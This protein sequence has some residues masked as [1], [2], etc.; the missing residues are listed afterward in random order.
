MAIHTLEN[1][2]LKVVINEMGGVIDVFTYGDERPFDIL[3][4]RIH[5]GTNFAG[6][7]SLFPMLPMVNRIRD[8]QFD[9]QGRRV[10]LPINES[11]DSHFFLHGNGWL[12]QWQCQANAEC[13]HTVLKLAM[14]SDIEGVCH[15]EAEQTYKLDGD[16]LTITLCLTNIGDE[17]FPFGIGFHP[18]FHCLP[19]T[20]IK[21]SA[22]GIWLE[23]VHYLPTDFMEHIPDV[24]NFG[25]GKTIPTV[26]IN[27]GY[28]LAEDGVNIILKHPNRVA[29]VVTSPCRY[30]QVY[31]PTGYSDFLCLEPQSQSVNSHKTLY[32]DD[33][34]NSLSIL[35]P[36]HSMHIVMT[37]KVHEW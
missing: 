6:N 17:V 25:Q 35:A 19:D 10:V 29:V 23:D 36:H 31:K 28:Y 24:F 27:N 11:V 13:E 26:W 8:N 21:F 1:G 33:S 22:Q 30:L 18:F 34:S 3:R 14:A 20:L 9:W 16:R 37:I 15:Y 2:R 5:D 4:P 12:T 32:L 7:S